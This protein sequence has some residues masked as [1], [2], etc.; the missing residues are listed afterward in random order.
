M[1]KR[2][3]P[4]IMITV[5]FLHSIMIADD[6]TTPTATLTLDSILHS[7][8]ITDPYIDS[9]PASGKSLY[10]KINILEDGN[11]TLKTAIDTSNSSDTVNT[12]GYFLDAS[13]NKL[14][15][16][17]VY[18]TQ[19]RRVS[20]SQNVVAGETYYFK[21]DNQESTADLT[22][23]MERGF[24]QL[25]NSFVR[26]IPAHEIH[27]RQT[28]VSSVDSKEVFTNRIDVVNSG[29]EDTKTVTITNTI[30]IDLNYISFASSS[31]WNCTQSLTQMSCTLNA[32]LAAYGGSKS[33]YI[34]TVS[35][36][37]SVDT[38]MD[39]K[40]DVNVT[41]NSAG[42][43]DDSKTQQ[44]LVRKITPAISLTK[45]AK[46]DGAIISKIVQGNLFNY[47]IEIENTTANVEVNET[48]VLL[49]DD[50]PSEF[51]VLSVTPD[52]SSDWDC[53]ASSGQHVECKLLNPLKHAATKSITVDVNATGTPQSESYNNT[54]T[55]SA[56]TPIAT[57]INA[58][59]TIPI[60]IESETYGATFTKTNT[61]SVVQI[62]DNTTYR[63][64]VKNSSN[65]PLDGVQIVDTFPSEFDFVQTIGYGNAGWSCQTVV[66]N[67]IDCSYDGNLSVGESAYLDVTLTA[68]SAG[69]GIVNTA[70]LSTN[71]TA[72]INA[73]A[74]IDITAYAPSNMGISKSVSQDVI[75]ENDTFTY[76]LSVI[77]LGGSQED[78]ITIEDTVPSDFTVENNISSGNWDCNLSGNSVSCSLASLASGAV[79]DSI[80][81]SVH[82]P[83][84]ITHDYTVTNTA[85]VT[86]QRNSTGVTAS[87]DVA[88]ISPSNAINLHLSSN[89]TV[90]YTGEPFTWELFITNNSAKTTSDVN[91][92]TIVP[93]DVVVDSIDSGGWSCDYN[94]TTREIACNT[95]G[96][97][98]TE[99]QKNIYFHMIAP[100]YETNVTDVVKVTTGIDPYVRDANVTT[101][102]LAKSV[103]LVFSQSESDKDPVKVDEE[104]TYSIKVKNQG[105]G[106]ASS[107]FNAS[108]VA[109]LINLDENLTD[110]DTNASGWDCNLSANNLSCLLQSDLAVGVESTPIMIG[111]KSPVAKLAVTD[112]NLTSDLSLSPVLKSIPVDI[113]DKVPANL[114]ITLSDSIDP[115]EANGDF[116]YTLEVQNSGSAYAVE[117]VVVN[118]ETI[119][120]ENF[121]L[122]SVSGSG[123][124]CTQSA[125]QVNCHLDTLAANS[126]S[127]LQLLVK[128]PDLNTTLEVNA[129]LYSDFVLESDSSDNS[130]SETT[131]VIKHDLNSDNLRPFSKVLINGNE[132]TNIYGE[133]FSIGNQIICQRSGSGCKEPDYDVNDWVEQY[134][135]NLDSVSHF[136]ASTAASLNITSNDEV[137]YAA[138]YWMG[139]IDRNAGEA[140]KIDEARFV[141]FRHESDSAY[142]KL[143]SSV[144]KFNWK[145][146]LSWGSDMF[147][148]QGVVDVTDYVKAHGAGEY[149]VADI[150]TTQ[151]YNVSAGWNLVVVVQDKTQTRKLKNITLFDGY[152]AVWRNSAYTEADQYPDFV[153]EQVDGFLTPNSGTVN[154]KLSLFALEGDKTL[155]DSITLTDESNNSH[156]LTN[157]LNP[158]DDVVNGTIS[159]AGV[160]VYSREP[161]LDN[162][163][164]VDI[165][166][167]DVS[168]IIGNG[169]SST[170]ITIN[171]DGDRFFLGMFAFSTELYSPKM[172]YVETMLQAD[173]SALTNSRVFNL[174][175]PI[176]FDVMIRNDENETARE[177]VLKSEIDTIYTQTSSSAEIKNVGESGY[178]GHSDLW[179]S[180]EIN[181]T[182]EQNETVPQTIF[183][184]RIGKSASSSNGGD[185]DYQDE[186]HFR[187]N[188]IIDGIPDAN[189]T[190]NVYKI[191]YKILNMPDVVETTIKPC[192]PDLNQSIYVK[193]NITE[194][195]DITHTGG[196]SDGMD[197]NTSNENHLFTQ[198]VDT[199]FPVDIVTLENDF[200][201][202]SRS[203]KGIVRLDLVEVNSSSCKEYKTLTSDYISFADQTRISPILQYHNANKNLAFRVHYPIDKYKRYALFN[204]VDVDSLADFKTMLENSYGTE[205]PCKSA[206]SSDLENCRACIYNPV[207]LVS[208][209]ACSRDT[210][211][212]R[213]KQ[214]LMETNSSLVGG[215]DYNLTFDANA[216][217]Y[218]QLFP[219]ST[220][221]SIKRS[222]IKPVGCGLADDNGTFSATFINGEANITNF[223]Y[224]NVGDVNVTLFDSAWTMVDQNST[225][226]LMSDCIVGSSSNSA[227]G[228]KYGC[229]LESSTQFSFHPKEFVNSV[230]LQ[231]DN[232]GSFTYIDASGAHYGSGYMTIKALID[233][234]STATNYTAGCFAKDINY[235]I[236]MSSYPAAYGAAKTDIFALKD[237]VVVNPVLHTF[238]TTE[239]NFSAGVSRPVIGINFAR[240][241]T[242]AVNAFDVNSSSLDISL[243]DENG[244]EGSGFATKVGKATY[245]YMR[246]YA[247]DYLSIKPD[248]FTAELF[249]EVY[250]N[251]ETG[252][253]KS[254]PNLATLKE[255]KVH[256]HWYIFNDL[257]TVSMGD[258]S[259]SSVSAFNG[260][261]IPVSGLRVKSIDINLSAGIKRPHCNKV[262]LVPDEAFK[263]DSYS[264]TIADKMH[265]KVCFTSQGDWLGQGEVG[266]SID[267]DISHKKNTKIDW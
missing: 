70:T 58:S 191:S 244:V 130:A 237:S 262:S 57:T 265:F 32:P 224:N 87:R 162:T 33:L 159:D 195:F 252:C 114:S 115:V 5:L 132:T 140:Y 71:K 3:N 127:Q 260:I 258:Y 166:T 249:Y 248:N 68:K 187:Y 257:H 13:C 200:S 263:Y 43:I 94:S 205:Y 131:Q 51:T 266:L 106:D 222:L 144:T 267:S 21:V 167:F 142:H 176:G 103:E 44:V 34:T 55:V 197:D 186:V 133:V 102:V 50:V 15:D 259:S 8:E 28:M 254:D 37:M 174:G 47:E 253:D 151:G 18:D 77:N 139:M 143:E 1:M 179:D 23:G 136:S 209:V 180:H 52:V 120:V 145:N 111:V 241:K 48:N 76:T 129:T 138:L 41:Y 72:D 148:Y 137:I 240:S 225:N 95:N 109:V 59:H 31:D 232:N 53:S 220:Y 89:P 154:S 67:K 213:P 204:G 63:L 27:I 245:Y 110:I 256:V 14:S 81:I 226:A 125:A 238:K 84:S 9:D 228:G 92:T 24:F 107:D 4:F 54:A 20:T 147:S 181:T 216:T 123:W 234:G 158:V 11:L 19:P 126:S 217:G 7:Q 155:N 96:N 30:P 39:I 6:C 42:T 196:L 101:E 199:P 134:F 165:D 218:N 97:Q 230:S 135:V 206:C 46:K 157:I 91:I 201:T 83:S 235:S 190:R 86:S 194:G 99:T 61:D 188:G 78:N 185:M 12:Y 183:E 40:T 75:L 141:Q 146:D 214:I 93:A 10:Y 62:D 82:A 163:S 246:L 16:A 233:N 171:S 247:P 211:S 2:L 243:E 56:D 202:D 177:I 221:T 152:Q 169:Q 150:Q 64:Y 242:E 124:V 100:N 105:T 219:L 121:I 210:F 73:S 119:S 60:T 108:N 172:C 104:F 74:T 255:S 173:Y 161:D 35:D 175:D 79:S 184:A 207:N 49:I 208:K 128:A 149:W 261:T 113:Y 250:C 26:T 69:S 65:M 182:N 212:I 227:V 236:G 25:E 122:N 160:V 90:V 192:D 156:T 203:H 229:N 117:D 193:P 198:L 251:E 264:T 153:K 170:E 189:L 231:N 17:L 66:S 168:H 98:L 88:L 38:Y 112:L 36:F 80:M 223:R 178:S 85:K 45:K 29:T 164:G 215:R 22:D 239:G 116:T 118:L